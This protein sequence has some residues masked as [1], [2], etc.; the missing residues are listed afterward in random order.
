MCKVSVERFHGING[1]QILWLPPAQLIDAYFSDTALLKGTSSSPRTMTDQ[2]S[3]NVLYN[4]ARKGQMTS[5]DCCQCR[6]RKV[7]V[8]SH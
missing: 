8:I 7:K 3:D 1:L 5:S 4:N 6:K 2:D